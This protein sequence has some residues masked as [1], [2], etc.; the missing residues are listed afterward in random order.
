VPATDPPAPT[1]VVTSATTW[2]EVAQGGVR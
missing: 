1:R 2:Q